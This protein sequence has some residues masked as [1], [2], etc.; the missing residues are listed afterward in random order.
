M[1]TLPKRGGNGGWIAAKEM[2]EETVAWLAYEKVLI[3]IG[4]QDFGF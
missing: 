2:M 3:V 1:L 4:Y